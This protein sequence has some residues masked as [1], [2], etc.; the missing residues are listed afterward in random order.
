MT[1]HELMIKTNHH[2]IKA[3]KLTEPQKEN[4]ARQL[5]SARSNESAKQNFYR[6]VKSPNNTDNIGRHMCPIFYMPSYNSGKKLKTIYNQTPKT[7][8]FSANMY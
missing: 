4:I 3:G 5:L 2:L 7:Y 6:G 1:A 8:L